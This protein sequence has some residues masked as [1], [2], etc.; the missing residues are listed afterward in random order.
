MTAYE[1]DAS[2]AAQWI[3]DEPNSLAPKERLNPSHELHVPDFFFLEID[4]ILW[5]R[6]QRKEI[7]IK[8]SEIGRSAFRQFPLQIHPFMSSLDLA[9]AVALKSH[10][11]LYDSLYISLAILLD[12]CLVTADKK[13]HEGIKKSGW[14]KKVVWIGGSEGL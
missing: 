5:K 4:N 2:V 3:F 12:V 9:Y 6:V 1:V 8:E 10:Q 13:L 14:L 7:T 11:S